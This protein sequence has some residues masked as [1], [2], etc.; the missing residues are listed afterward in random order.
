MLLPGTSENLVREQM[1]ELA[2]L[3]RTAAFTT[4]RAAP[5]VWTR[6]LSPVSTGPSSART[7]E[8]SNGGRLLINGSAKAVSGANFQSSSE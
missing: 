1:S 7:W 2:E 3:A 5:A 4:S 8:A 6:S